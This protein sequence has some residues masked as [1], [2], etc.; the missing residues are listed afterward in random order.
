MTVH[1]N[2]KSTDG[3]VYQVHSMGERMPLVILHGFT[4]TGRG[5][6]KAFSDIRD[7]RRLIA[8][9]LLGH[10]ETDAPDDPH[11]YRMESAAADIAALID[12]ETDEPVDLFGYSMGGR[13]AL[14]IAL[15]YPNRIRS[16]I[17]ESASP[18]LNDESERAVRR[19]R[20]E[21]LADSIERGGI[22]AF[23][24]K[25]ERIPLF[26]TQTD[27]MRESLRAERL[28]QRPRGLANSLRGMG[29]GVQ[30]SLWGRLDELSMPVLLITGA[31]DTK[32]TEIARKMTDSIP[33][34]QHIV[35]P[36]AGHTVHLE[37]PAAFQAAMLSFLAG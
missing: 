30:P 31:L 9:D 13:L 26:A 16:L 35:I 24:E 12:A 1:M 4:G 20:D 19:Q 27:A 11:R 10:G 5:M 32:F 36:D 37:Q 25:W 14:Y 29:T 6:L 28:A 15:N 18:G 33:K 17:L 21:K 2:F 8:P 3:V 7:S 22:E 23:V 34:A